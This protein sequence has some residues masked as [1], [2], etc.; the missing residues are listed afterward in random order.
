MAA[1]F[2]QQWLHHQLLRVAAPAPREQRTMMVL[3]RCRF[4]GA[5]QV[6]NDRGLA[7]RRISAA[8]AARSTVD[9]SSNDGPP[10]DKLLVANRGEIACRVM[11]TARRMGIRTVAV[12]SDADDQ[13][14]MDCTGQI[15]IPPA[16]SS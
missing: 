14:G 16:I 15:S 1:G 4:R 3:T 2:G 10:I 13:V 8:S 6:I 12:F 7:W 9:P 11:R 5:A